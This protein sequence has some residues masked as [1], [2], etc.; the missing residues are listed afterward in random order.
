MRHLLYFPILLLF[1]CSS[2]ID[3]AE[4]STINLFNSHTI[5]FIG[6]T[7][8]ENA[9]LF[10]E[11]LSKDPEAIDTLIINSSGGDVIGGMQIGRLVNK[12]GLSV[13][14]PNFCAS[15][16][17]NYIVT[18]SDNVTIRT[19][20][21]LGWHGGATQP[22]YSTLM[23]NSSWLAKIQLFFSDADEEQSMSDFVDKW[24][25]EEEIFFD[26]VGVN[27]AVTI[28]GMMPGLK[29]QREL[30]LYSYDPETLNR[31]GLNITFKGGEQ[32]QLSKEDIKNVQ[33][34]TLSK[35]ELNTLLKLH[36]KLINENKITLA[37]F[38]TEHVSRQVNSLNV[39]S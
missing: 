30:S 35:E 33:V 39:T 27:Q 3:D 6:E 12:Y 5:K 20:A 1:S 24:Q 15:S 14:V 8:L 13:I 10:E 19:G 17:A 36:Q 38:S 18:A 7:S 26:L 16:C 2:V 25:K 37:R 11:A 9:D 31:L 32:T 34:F 21:L 29:E 4:E 28:L 22:F 23:V